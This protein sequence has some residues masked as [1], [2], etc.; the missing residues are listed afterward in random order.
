MSD[1][2]LLFGGSIIDT[3]SGI[4]Q[5]DMDVLMERG[6]ITD[7]LPSGQCRMEGVG[8]LDCTGT[9]ILPGL[10][11]CH[12]H[13]GFLAAED[14]ETRKTIRDEAGIDVTIPGSKLAEWIF[15]EFVRRGVT[16]IR[17]VGSPVSVIMGFA[18][19]IRNGKYTG[20]ELFYT[21][22]MLE[23]SP[24][25]WA[26]HNEIIA[27][28]TVAIDSDAD[29]VRVVDQLAE[30][31]V[32]CLKTFNK[33]DLS[34]YKMVLTTALKYNLPIVHDPGSALF[35]DIP[36]DMAL[37]LGVRC[38]EHGKSPWPVV[39]QD[40]LASELCSIKAAGGLQEAKA[41]FG[42]RVFALGDESINDDKLST[43]MRDMKSHDACFCP[44]LHVFERF[45]AEEHQKDNAELVD[46]LTVLG[47]IQRRCVQAAAE[48]GVR[49]LSGHDGY[50]PAYTIAEMLLLEAAGVS[51]LEIIRGATLYPARWL[52][53]DDRYGF[54]MPGMTA[55]LLVVKDNP[56]DD[57]AN[58]AH[59]HSV[60]CHGRCYAESPD[61]Y[62]N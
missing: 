52:G 10:F 59:V 31:G 53:V 25:T 37:E 17:D 24:L 36:M 62:Q 11:E 16:Q 42:A 46:R 34:V 39:L 50:L 3:V 23:K 22:P 19:D 33:F 35:H 18:D 58:I 45:L 43:L 44:T 5:D 30:N 6:I 9:Y 27:D 15:A 2:C 20:P 28:F 8:R 51:P 21:G 1:V 49:I 48:A 40:D 29:A 47:A 13:L 4:I 12:A 7:V 32:A 54:I 61:I 56:L 60:V 38:F 55:N 41:D 14:E 57:I 26:K